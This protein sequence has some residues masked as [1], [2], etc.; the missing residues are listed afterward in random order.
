M[1]EQCYPLKELVSLLS[2]EQ[3]SS[4]LV[5]TVILLLLLQKPYIMKSCGRSS[6][7]LLHV[8]QTLLCSPHHV[9]ITGRIKLRMPEE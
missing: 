8:S 5:S 9:H 2:H 7:F 4:K 6:Y 1:C 3:L